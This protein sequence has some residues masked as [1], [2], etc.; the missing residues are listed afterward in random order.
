MDLQLQ[1]RYLKI[2][3]LCTVHKSHHLS[4]I[5]HCSTCRLQRDGISLENPNFKKMFPG[6]WIFE[7][8]VGWRVT[9]YYNNYIY[10]HNYVES[11]LNHTHAAVQFRNAVYMWLYNHEYNKFISTTKM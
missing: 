1:K 3:Y 8:K 7:N 6:G 11:R 2:L 9:Y 10:T 4:L 5:R